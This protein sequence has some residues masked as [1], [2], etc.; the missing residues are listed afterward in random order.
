MIQ[1]DG[2]NLPT[3]L[4]LVAQYEYPKWAY[5]PTKSYQLPVRPKLQPL[6]FQGTARALL[7]SCGK[8]NKT[9]SGKTKMDSKNE[10]GP[11]KK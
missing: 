9:H 4:T 10:G 7:N 11:T 1:F 6:F 3:N 2:K 8:Q 5:N